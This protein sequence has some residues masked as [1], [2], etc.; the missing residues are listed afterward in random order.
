MKK[1]KFSHLTRVTLLLAVFF[2]IDKIVAFA[3]LIIVARQF[4]LSHELD[5]FNVANNLPDM[6]FALI[7]GGALAMAF[8]PVLTEMLT[9]QGRSQAWDLFS[10]IA[11]LAFLVT[12]GFSIL[13]AIFA[14]PLVSWRLGIAP[15]FNDQQQRLVAEL[16]RLNLIATLIFS[17]SGLVIAGLQ[18]NQHFLLPAIA[19]VLYNLG[20]IFGALVLAPEKGLTLGP[21]T[22]PAF[23]L[24][25]HGLV[26]GVILGA[27]LH[28]AI[29]IPGLIRYGFRWTPK[30]GL[31]TEAVRKVLLLLGP[32]LV[33]MFFIQLTFIV[34]DNLASRLEAGSPSVL[35]YGWMIMQVPETLIGTAIATAMLPSLAEMVARQDWVTFRATIERAVQVLMALTLPVAAVLAAGLRPLLSLAFGFDVAGTDLLLWVTRAYLLGLFGQCLKE[36]A[37]RTFYAQQDAITPLWTA[38]VNLALYALVGS[39]FYRIVGAAGISLGDAVAFTFE[40]LLLMWL[41]TRRQQVRFTLA[42]ALVRALAAAVLGGGVAYLLVNLN[43]PGPQALGALLAMAAGVL[44]ALPVV[45]KELRLLVQL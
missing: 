33:T 7:S 18:A 22:L 29:Q 13:I 25:V 43:L 34:R 32:R 30:I 35:T 37:V 10:R 16:M 40:A 45:W 39:Q 27:A 12:A 20:Q 1:L 38:G 17:L 2:G 44:V 9:K 31:K 6:L 42:P 14:E 4:G 23:G 11:N 26:Y 8:I 15:G 24:G 36:V 5:A 19:P 21:V 41:F 3:R 28:L